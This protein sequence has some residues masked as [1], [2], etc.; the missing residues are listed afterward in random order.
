[1]RTP[2]THMRRM[3]S[4]GTHSCFR[5]LEIFLGVGISMKYRL[6]GMYGGYITL[7]FKGF[8]MLQS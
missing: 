8:G 7:Q 1:M 4:D 6:I 3:L 2:Y 5:E